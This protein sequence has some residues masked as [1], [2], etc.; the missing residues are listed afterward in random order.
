MPGYCV[1]GTVGHKVVNG[2]K[3]VEIDGQWIDVKLQVQVRI[4]ML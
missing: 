2:A 4:T 1:A 3:R